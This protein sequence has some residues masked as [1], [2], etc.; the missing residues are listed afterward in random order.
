MSNSNHPDEAQL[1]AWADRELD[2]AGMPRVGEHVGDCSACRE[3][4]AQF[5]ETLDAAAATL[6]T[7]SPAP[8]QPWPALRPRLNE[9][10]AGRVQS[11]WR[12]F[13]RIDLRWAAAAA[14]LVI[15]VFVLKLFTGQTVSAAELLEKAAVRETSSPRPQR[16]RVKTR[17]AN[18]VRPAVSSM[19]DPAIST[20]FRQANFPWDDP[21]SARSFSRWRDTLPEKRDSVSRVERAYRIT[22]S[23]PEGAI[24][25]A[26]IT[27]TDG[28]FRPVQETFRFRNDEY[29]EITETLDLEPPRTA[30]APA[31]PAVAVPPT[32]KIGPIDE[33]RVVAALHDIGADLGEPIEITR[34]EKGIEVQALIAHPDR[35]RQLRS[36]LDPLGVD[37]RIIR[38]DAVRAPAGRSAP[39]RAVAS[40]AVR[41]RLGSAAVELIFDESDAALT[42]AHALRALA[43]RFPPDV[44][45]QLGPQ[46]LETL[47]YIRGNHV[48]RLVAAAQ[49]LALAT[50]GPAATAPVLPWQGAADAALEAA[51]QFDRLATEALTSEAAD[52]AKA[53]PE[54][55]SAASLLLARATALQP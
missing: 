2:D 15:A 41:E 9:L 10:D 37:L 38:P 45:A 22:T 35:A 46:G 13:P 43:R 7:E 31:Q 29:V 51:Q 5:R 42:R 34:T 28:D 52:P 17:R 23:T 1:L 11:R 55:A 48:R 40:N 33:L 39:E 53:L 26:T 32:R 19:D 20:L 3:R 18:Y 44:E 24:A 27:I 16:I 12:L 30:E 8:P 14:V 4:V 47:R 50:Q 21:L 25:E 54:L 36:V 49:Q 6:R